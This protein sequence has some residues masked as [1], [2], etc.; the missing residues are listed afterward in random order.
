M[1]KS[2]LRRPTA[3]NKKKK[4]IKKYKYREKAIEREAIPV[5]RHQ[6]DFTLLVA[7]ILLCFV[8]IVMIT[9][10]SYYFSYNKFGD[11][12]HFFKRQIIW[13]AL[14]LGVMFFISNMHYKVFKRFSLPTYLL[15]IFFLI[16]VLLIGQEING[17]KRWLFGF[18]PSEFA[19]IATTIFMA[20][21]ISKNYK[22][23]KTW[24]YLL[25]VLILVGIPVLL[26]GVE[27]MSTAL[28]VL[29]IGGALIFLSGVPLR[30]LM[31]MVLPVGGLGTFFLMLP[32]LNIPGLSKLAEDLMYRINRI[33]VWKNP[34][35]D[36]LGG[37]FQTIQ[38][39][40]AV[41]S[42]GLFGVGL[43]QSLQKRGFIPEAHNDIIFSIICEELGLLGAVVV[44]LLFTILIWRGIKVAMNAPDLFSS[45]LAAGAVTQV[46]VQV[47]INVAVNTNTIPVTGM[48]LPFISYGGSSLLFLMMSMGILLNV[49][50]YSRN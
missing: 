46:A 15:S 1:V 21:Y 11:S 24:K 27:N 5:K 13:L 14:G 38:S 2:E 3:V 35:S 33:Q 4:R 32:V 49:S 17:A 31:L 7:I 26:I 39:L 41:G 36:P 45:L 23:V 18:Q 10:S 16:L 30:R 40:Y 34:W 44:I 8:G 43:G 22:Y 19:K 25:N 37:G 6:C 20:S 47:I 42:G 12:L 29:T 48:P 28:V 9:S 50:R